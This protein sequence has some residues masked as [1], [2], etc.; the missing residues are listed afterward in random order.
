MLVFTDSQVRGLTPSIVG[1]S[2]TTTKMFPSLLGPGFDNGG[3]NLGGPLGPQG[4]GGVVPSP[5]AAVGPAM[6]IVPSS[7]LYEG[8]A[9]EIRASGSIYIHGTSPTLNFVLQSGTSMTAS[10]N[11]TFATL[12][13]AVSLTTAAQYPFSLDLGI[14]GD[15]VSGIVQVVWASFAVDGINFELNANARS[16]TN[17]VAPTSLTGVKFTGAGGKPAL[18]IVF[19]VTFGVSDAANVANLTQFQAGT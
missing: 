2:G 19:G 4:S 5:A 10:S 1:G 12:H 11:T 15:S 8:Q 14:Q 6:L 13:T 18:N 7:G 17:Y 16:D 3:G 9:I